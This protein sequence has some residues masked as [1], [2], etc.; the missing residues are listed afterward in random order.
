MGFPFDDDTRMVSVDK[1]VDLCNSEPE[2]DSVTANAR[3]ENSP[4]NCDDRPPATA[5]LIHTCSNRTDRCVFLN[6]KFK[7]NVLDGI[8]I[9]V[10][11]FAAKKE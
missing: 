6:E 1:A 3:T 2:T 4:L 7:A 8:L 10:I 5:R 9:I 11:H